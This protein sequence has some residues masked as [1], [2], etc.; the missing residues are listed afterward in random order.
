MSGNKKS[1]P[2]LWVSLWKIDLLKHQLTVPE[3]KCQ[4][5]F[6]NSLVVLFLAVFIFKDKFILYYK[7]LNVNS[8]SNSIET[9]S[10]DKLFQSLDAILRAKV[11]NQQVRSWKKIRQIVDCKEFEFYWFLK[12]EVEIFELI[13][14]KIKNKVLNF[15][16]NSNKEDNRT[17]WK[18]NWYD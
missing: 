12:P 9:S 3:Q 4:I 6:W 5:E 8:R 14:Q 11:L 2:D 7:K 18:I 1:I 10:F 13:L 17:I 15:V 16:K